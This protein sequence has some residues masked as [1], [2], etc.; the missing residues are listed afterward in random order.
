[1]R[2]RFALVVAALPSAPPMQRHRNNGIDPQRAERRFGVIGPQ[3][4]E[5]LGHSLARMIFQAQHCFAQ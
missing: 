5:Q 3:F 1:M 2:D 4:A